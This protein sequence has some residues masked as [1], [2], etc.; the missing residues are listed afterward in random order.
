MSGHLYVHD[1]DTGRALQ[2][3]RP[4]PKP[5]QAAKV[6]LWLPEDAPP[7][8]RLGRVD[9]FAVHAA[10]AATALA[11]GLAHCAALLT[12][13]TVRG[14]C[15]LLRELPPDAPLPGTLCAASPALVE[16]AV[17]A[18]APRP[19]SAAIVPLWLL[20]PGACGS[21][22]AAAP[23]AFAALLTLQAP[24]AQ[25]VVPPRVADKV[26]A[27]LPPPLRAT[28]RLLQALPVC[29]CGG[30]L[31]HLVP[32]LYVALPAPVAAQP[33]LSQHSQRV[34]L[35]GALLHNT[36]V[37]GVVLLT[38][39]SATGEC[40]AGQLAEPL[41]AA[42]PSEVSTPSSSAAVFPPH[43]LVVSANG[44]LT[45]AAA[46]SPLTR[47]PTLL[48]VRH[49][50]LQHL[51]RQ[52]GCA[53]TLVEEEREEEDE[54]EEEEAPPP[55]RGKR[56]RSPAPVTTP[57][58]VL[59]VP[60]PAPAPCRAGEALVLVLTGGALLADGPTSALRQLWQWEGAGAALWLPST[61]SA[62]PAWVVPC[63]SLLT[64]CQ[65]GPLR[66]T[67]LCATD[68]A[69]NAALFG[70]GGL[71]VLPASA[72]LRGAVLDAPPAAAW[73]GAVGG[74]GAGSAPLLLHPKRTPPPPHTAGSTAAARWLAGTDTCTTPHCPC[75]HG[76]T[77][78]PAVF[79]GDEAEVAKLRAMVAGFQSPTHQPTY[80]KRGFGG[81]APRL[82]GPPT[83]RPLPL[84]P[85]SAALATRHPV[86][87]LPPN[88]LQSPSPHALVLQVLPH[89]ARA[90]AAAAT[91][92][93][94]VPA[95]LF[96]RQGL[97]AA[98]LCEVINTAT[99]LPLKAL[100]VGDGPCPRVWLPVTRVVESLP[101]PH[102]VCCADVALLRATLLPP[103]QRPPTL[104]L[105]GTC[106]LVWDP[107]L[108]RPLDA[109]VQG[110]ATAADLQ[111][112]WDALR[113]ADVYLTAAWTDAALSCWALP[114][115]ALVVE[116]VPPDLSPRAAAAACAAVRVHAAAAC[117]AGVRFEVWAPSDVALLPPPSWLA[118]HAQHHNTTRA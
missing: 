88:R 15:A 113:T 72:A 11:G 41:A 108:R 48:D 50:L 104:P 74:C 52:G 94:L 29:A 78:P 117:A 66:L 118:A 13:D 64:Q 61:A 103:R 56:E 22:E 28:V 110:P 24:Y 6:L 87:L 45:S 23:G 59:V 10:E 80:P 55:R 96:A 47:W 75:W 30:P 34:R 101:P 85:S 40:G 1:P 111:H 44:H 14:W 12:E 99:R 32:P 115:G 60:A 4:Q 76:A 49:G 65:P 84:P 38:P 82:L 114:P 19:C 58:H 18:C 77:E 105:A 70:G 92:R 107:A 39:P 36:Y 67:P 98:I 43:S 35:L 8:R 112:I 46:A 42:L 17:A 89:L 79:G 20:Q 106:T 100:P 27:A 97:A 16:A 116:V 69:L 93:D 73:T 102:H 33:C 63:A 109:G 53:R 71:C 54:E 26:R 31:D 86:L 91:P 9:T 21:A 62:A 95:L 5:R 37:D 83:P 2:L 68:G 7:S 57:A 25:A 90:A 3:L 81:G 51:R